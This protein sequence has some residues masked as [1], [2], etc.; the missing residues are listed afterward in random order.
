MRSRRKSRP[1]SSSM[2]RYDACVYGLSFSPNGLPLGIRHRSR[3]NLCSLLLQF[4]TL[5]VRLLTEEASQHKRNSED[6]ILLAFQTLDTEKKG[7]LDQVHP[8][9]PFLSPKRSV[10]FSA[11]SSISCEFCTLL[12]LLL[13]G[14]IPAFIHCVSAR[15]SLC[16]GPAGRAT[17][18]HDH[19]WRE[20][21][22]R[23][24]QGNDIIRSRCRRKGEIRRGDERA[25][26]CKKGSI[27]DD[28]ACDDDA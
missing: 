16:L 7:Y 20:I 8:A 18:S 1:G 23:R 9:F 4:E 14:C 17:S 2:K 13:P 21:L 25:G 19:L 26:Q 28:D 5:V 11:C 24:G 27:R 10:A 15:L 12:P 3:G 6:E 22:C